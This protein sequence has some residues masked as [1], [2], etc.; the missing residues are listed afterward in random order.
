MVDH[1]EGALLV[2]AGLGSG[3][4][5][6]LTER[7]RRLLAET[8]ET[9][10][11]LAVTF[12]NKAA[13]EMQKRLAD[14]PAASGR[15]TVGTLHSFCL[16]V[17]ARRGERVGVTGTPQVF[18]RR[19]DRLQLLDEAARNDPVLLQELRAAGEQK[20]QRRRLNDWLDGIGRRK[21]RLQAPE[22]V[23]DDEI[24]RHAYEVYNG[25]LRTNGALDYDDLLFL[26]HRL[27]VENPTVAAFYRRLYRYIF[28][29][30]A[31]DLNPAQ[32]FL[33]RALCGEE[34]RNVMMVGDPRQAIFVFNEANPKFMEDFR[35]D[36]AAAQLVLEENFRSSRK[37]LEVA[38]RLTPA[39]GMEGNL[40]IEGEVKLLRGDTPDD[41]AHKVAD[42]IAALLRDGHPEIQGTIKLEQIGVI[43]RTR[44]ALSAVEEEFVGRGWKYYRPNAASRISESRLFSIFEL[45]L[46]LKVNPVDRFHALQL[47][48]HIN[49]PEINETGDY[50]RSFLEI[51]LP[52]TERS[53]LT[54]VE[55][56]RPDNF[57]ASFRAAISEFASLATDPDDIEHRGISED[58]EVWRKALDLYV[59]TTP[60]GQIQLSGFLS[61]LAL[62]TVMAGKT[63]GVALLSGH[64]AKG[65]EFDIVFL[66]GLG[67]G[68][69]PDYRATTPKLL[70]EE[71]RNV[72]VAVT[73]ARRVLVLSYSRKRQT[74]WGSIV[75][76]RPSQF[77]TEMGFGA[78][79]A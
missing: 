63:T 50:L 79:V 2:L 51:T 36:F 25:A 27:F 42:E 44:Y 72:F 57:P 45:A 3:K 8:G 29:D 62:G 40:A 41:E 64:A 13:Q 75:A 69:F 33:L 37:I 31:Q 53:V 65:L 34:H 23:D 10:H 14:I 56:F 39:F 6:V 21:N 73:R 32:Y 58:A 19:E 16:E 76:Q 48:E 46:R 7:I 55:K 60:G 18:E 15:L 47:A 67:E 52:Q 12:T 78:A 5:L 77:L 26:T 74:P 66:V 22:N 43:G 59:R 4:T 30:E 70:E 35:R 49:L 61:H 20:E 17:L 9:F 11:I 68:I 28:L 54:A 24:L 71:K 38:R 1:G